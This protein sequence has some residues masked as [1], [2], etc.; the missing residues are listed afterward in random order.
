MERKENIIDHLSQEEMQR[1]ADEIRALIDSEPELEDI[2]VTD[3]MHDRMMDRIQKYEQEKALSNLSEENK[4]ALRL[5]K[6]LQNKR[7][8]TRMPR[9]RKVWLVLAATL[10]LVT[11]VG[12]TSV[13]R[14]NIIVEM[15]EKTFGDGDKTY[16]DSEEID[17]VKNVTEEQAY[18]DVKEVLGDNIVSVVY[19]PDNSEFLDIQLDKELQ[20]ATLYYST[21][22][23][24][25][26]FQMVSRYVNS[27]IGMDLEDELL[28][29][30][31][32]ELP[33]TSVQMKEY[34]VKETGER[35]YTAKFSYKNCKYFLTGIIKKEEFEKIIKNLHFF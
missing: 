23:T 11:S 18:A 32:I 26:S 31:K 13:G 22:Q 34:K 10:V 5:G 27:S 30:Y 24:I 16:V 8:K 28:Q 4:E 33:E 29:E 14:K 15:L 3:D 21:G 25:I 2:C 9:K 35:E 17:P 20:E 12:V 6:E 1:E 19:L 7:K